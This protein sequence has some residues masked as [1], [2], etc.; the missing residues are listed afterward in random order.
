MLGLGGELGQ[1]HLVGAERS[2]DLLAVHFLG[3]VQPL[4][5]TITIMGHTG[6]FV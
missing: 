2:F 1:R 3:P 5:V 4:G 6:R